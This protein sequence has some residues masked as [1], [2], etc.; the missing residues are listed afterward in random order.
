MSFAR[1]P[2]ELLYQITNYLDSPREMTALMKT[3]RLLY[4]FFRPLRYEHNIQHEQSSALS[5]VAAG[6]YLQTVRNMITNGANI[7]TTKKNR[8]GSS[9]DRLM[10]DVTP[11][12]MAVLHGH[13]AVTVLLV[14]SGANINTQF[15]TPKTTPL[16][17]AAYWGRLEIVAY[18]VKTMIGRCG[19]LQDIP[20]SGPI[21]EAVSRNQVEI[22]RFL[23]DKGA[24]I[25][26]KDC[27]GDSLL[28]QAINIW[29]HSG[30]EVGVLLIERGADVT[31][32]DYCGATPLHNAV[33]LGF[34]DAVR[35]LLENGADSEALT[36]GDEESPLDWIGHQY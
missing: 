18:L 30:G 9:F 1:L 26:S 24:D 20:Y 29:G 32:K 10:E 6:G 22:V 21:S 33:R 15:F 4:A 36:D 3:N 7:E 31:V 17:V 14:E 2:S 35:L 11:L 12:G 23:L 5:W 28:C 25:E 27:H 8:K 19:T 16:E 13:Y 34:A